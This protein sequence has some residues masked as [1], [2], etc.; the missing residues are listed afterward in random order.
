MTPI[1]VLSDILE[2]YVYILV[3]DIYSKF[4][5]FFPSSRVKKKKNDSTNFA[6]ELRSYKSNNLFIYYSLIRAAML[7]IQPWPTL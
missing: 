1:P 6:L 7:G 3:G 4:S 5:K 2:K